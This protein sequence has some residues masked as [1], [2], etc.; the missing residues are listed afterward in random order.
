MTSREIARTLL[1]F[2]AASGLVPYSLLRGHR[3]VDMTSNTT[4]ITGRGSGIGRGLAEAL[5][6]LGKQVVIAGRRQ[7]TQADELITRRLKDALDLV[8]IRIL[9]LVA[10]GKTISFAERGLL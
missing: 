2:L 3:L 9:D 4:L 5:H 10:G 8:D 7:S 1:R 6:R